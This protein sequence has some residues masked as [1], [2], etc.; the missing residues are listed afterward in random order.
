MLHK[1]IASQYQ[2]KT[3]LEHILD[4]PDTYIGSVENTEMKMWVYN[5]EEN[6]MENRLVNIVPGLYKIFDEILVNASD[7]HIRAIQ[8]D[9]ENKV[10]TIKVNIDVE[11]N[12]IS[13]YNNGN[14]IPV[15]THPEHNIYVPEML[16]GQ[17]L[18]SGNFNKEEKKIVGGKNGYG[19]SLGNIYSTKF[20]I[21]TVDHVTKKKYIQEFSNNMRDKKEPV[22]TKCSVKPYTKVTF[23]PDLPRFGLQTLTDDM[24]AL[25]YK[26]VYDMTATTDK[27]VSVF[28][29]EKKLET[30]QFEQYM[31]LYIGKKSE[32]PRI[33][34]Q[35]NDRWELAVCLSSDEEFEHV[36]FVNGICTYK[37]GK[38]VD[39]VST[40]I[41]NR[42]S[43][44]LANKGRN[45]MNIKAE[46]IK[47]NLFL[48]LKTSIENPSFDSQTKENLTTTSNKF[49]STCKVSDK[50][51]ERLAKTEI[52]KRSL[53]LG[54][55]K[56]D[57]G[58]SKKESNTSKSRTVRVPKLDDANLA[59]TPKSQ[60]C[61]LILTE[62]DSAKAL[63]VAGLSVVGRDRFG[64][65]PLKGKLLNVREATTEQLIKNKEINN[66]K[67]IMG[68]QQYE[69]GKSTN[70][71]KDSATKVKKV[72][73]NLNELRYGRIMIFTDE[74]YD[75]YHIKGL[76]INFIGTYWPEL[77]K[78][79]NFI[80]SLAT[81]IV[82]CTKGKQVIEFYT[83]N[84]YK[85][86]KESNTEKGWRIKYYK[87]LG[88][89]S[90][91]EAKE[92]F[93]DLE[94]K[95][96]R[97]RCQDDNCYD[98]I[99]L[100]FAK[101]HA[102]NR[103]D[104]LAD[105]DENDI[106][107]NSQKDV[108]IHDFTHKAL[109]HFSEHDN[110]RSIPSLC[111]GLKPAQRK[112]LYGCFKR[113]LVKEAKVAQL[114]GY[115]S[116]H[117]A[118]HHGE[119]SLVECIIAMAQNYVAS[120][121]INLLNPNGQFGTRLLN[122]KDASSPRYIFTNLN[123]LTPI[124]FNKLDEPLLE[125]LDDD[126]QIIEPRWYLPILPMILV[127]GS[128]GIGTGY[129]TNIPSFNPLTIADNIYNLMDG[130][131]LAEMTPW[132]RGFKGQI[133][134][135]TEKQYIC[136]GVYHILNDTTLEIT[137]L[138]IGVWTAPYFEYLDEL[139][140]DKSV[141][142]AKKKKKQC[143]TSY[144]KENDCTD[145]NVHIIVK[146]PK[147]TMDK[148]K[149]DLSELEADFHLS[150]N[151]NLSNMHMFNSKNQIT[152]YDSTE[153]IMEEFYHLR[154]DYYLK[155]KTYWL[156]RMKKELDIMAAKIRFI[157]YV[158]DQKIDIRQ[159]EEDIIVKLEELNFPKFSPSDLNPNHKKQQQQNSNDDEEES[160]EQE[161]DKFSYDYLLRM[162]IRTLTEKV[163]NEMKNQYEKRM[164]EYKEL[165]NKTEKTLWKED[166]DIFVKVYKKVL[167]EYME[168]MNNSVL[169]GST[170]NSAN[171][172]TKKIT[173]KKKTTKVKVV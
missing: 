86:W 72:Y 53:A 50:F 152:K 101:D 43:K 104:W 65:F 1:N 144:N 160:K 42:L 21:E 106:L 141:T 3:Q 111:D 20:I 93:K 115:I 110:H 154:L 6:K 156:I 91:K 95:L 145:T 82:K 88:T 32:T 56:D 92:Y 73:Q 90:S 67:K 122:G 94:N 79:P 127:N 138:P 130:K 38:H 169:N 107:E 173:I 25:L 68:L 4:L 158:R 112:V 136:K 123:E 81:P 29:N 100:G 103:K 74:D 120:N 30:K 57:M 5:S 170:N 51:I 148:Y 134:K 10:T 17:L 131:P 27:T 66:I 143:I 75:G 153:S 105:Y 162:Q 2:K 40:H 54:Q 159:A 15:V 119:T 33:Y 28:L 142:D 35:V 18:T 24:L 133:T 13:V 149:Q 166:L 80:I 49:G 77:L 19:A 151:I 62:G 23:Y 109:K 102:N 87:G 76:L 117:T 63:A 26:R 161:S 168:N 129:S 47:K 60:E 31:D 97:Y 172:K 9:Y 89:S 59:G 22:I 69:Y 118:Y 36:S 61:T 139:I 83:Q 45:K 146:I 171:K 124:L 121:N 48:F 163:K 128:V 37:G 34:E 135:S 58:L 96:I 140:I 113:N 7:H 167:K 11:K 116:E 39:Y 157:E 99:K 150:K 46:H 108:S 137:E 70:G 12:E 71:K 85:K 132:Y 98:A 155:R 8:K 165:E 41:A 78:F 84:E 114:A 64:V 52:V 55:H 44:F 125:F 14:G 126:G 16:F 147:I 164:A